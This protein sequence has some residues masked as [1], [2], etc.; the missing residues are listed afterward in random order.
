MYVSAIRPHLDYC[1]QLW[2]P[3]EGPHLD[4]L[5]KLQAYYTRLIPE[6]RE[7]TYPERLKALNLQSVQRRFDRYRI[8]YIRKILKNLVP[9]PGITQ[10]TEASH[11]LGV[12]VE[13]PKVKSKL[14]HDSFLVRGPRTFNSLPKEL[15]ELDVS[16]DTFK[17][18][19]DDFL[20]LIPDVPRTYGQGGN[21]LEEHIKDWRWSL[22]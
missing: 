1:S 2:G 17:V 21:D 14:R 15:R 4:K 8:T 7:L 22:H 11:Q 12:M 20:E 5:E 9:N 18:H 3:G 19:L 16:M 10:R 13:I 6:I